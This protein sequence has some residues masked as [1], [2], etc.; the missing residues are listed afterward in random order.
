M[1]ENRAAGIGDPRD[2]QF[3]RAGT[4]E[5]SADHQHQ[6]DDNGRRMAEA[7]EGIGGGYHA[8]NQGD[9]Q[10]GEGNQ[11]IAPAIPHEKPENQA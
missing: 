4:G 10:G 7:A 8:E 11:I 3:D 9:H 6:R 5:S 1:S 2:Q